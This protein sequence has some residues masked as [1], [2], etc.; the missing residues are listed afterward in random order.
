MHNYIAE[1]IS[2]EIQKYT[3][4]LFYDEN[5]NGNLPSKAYAS[6]ILITVNDIFLLINAG[7]TFQDVELSNIG[8]M[9]ENEFCT[10]GGGLI[11]YEPND[12]FY[13][14]NKLDIS[15]FRLDSE[16]IETFKEKYKF[17]SYNK[18]QFNHFSVEQSKY[19]V[20]GYP[21]KM[22]RKDFPTKNI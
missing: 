20:F 2:K 19:L 7:H 10:I 12:Q 5:P 18:I 15:V 3:P 14:P 22:T 9:I 16:T 17:L 13:E 4:Q 1:L 21:E 6:S 11:K 8:I